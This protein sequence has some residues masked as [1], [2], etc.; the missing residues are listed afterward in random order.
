MSKLALRF[1]LSRAVLPPHLARANSVSL[2]HL[3]E[4]CAWATGAPRHRVIHPDIRKYTQLS[5]SPLPHSQHL[6]RPSVRD[7]CAI[8]FALA[9]GPFSIVPLNPCSCHSN[10][11]HCPSPWHSSPRLHPIPFPAGRTQSLPSII[12]SRIQDQDPLR[13][14]R[15]GSAQPEYERRGLPRTARSS[16]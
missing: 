15:R 11:C 3:I 9:H 6:G 12:V 16:R 13:P 10:P 2:T 8:V 14:S 5:I 1:E 4:R 7:P